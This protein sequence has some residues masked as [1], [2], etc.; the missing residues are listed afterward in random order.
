MS[1]K[2]LVSCLIFIIAVLGCSKTPTGQA[3]ASE[4]NIYEDAPAIEQQA[5]NQTIEEITEENQTEEQEIQIKTGEEYY[6]ELVN[7]E[8][9]KENI[10]IEEF[11]FNPESIVST[12]NNISLSIDNIK[13]EIKSEYWGK[14]IEITATILNNG[15]RTF[16]PKL[17]VL[18]YDEKDF[19]EE[20]LKPKAEIQ[21]DIE[22]LNAGEHTTR[23]AIVSISFDD[24]YL[25]KNFKLVLVDAADPANKPLVVAETNF[26]PLK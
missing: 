7:D 11:K 12:Q 26:E 8:S 5:G 15:N 22:Q 16:K 4:A 3:V 13:H 6:D 10:N 25:T 1:N 24:L 21:F 23:Q 19:K 20:W 18:L 14:I 2:I 9:P 17:L